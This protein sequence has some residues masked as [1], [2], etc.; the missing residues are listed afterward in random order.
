MKLRPFRREGEN[1]IAG[2]SFWCPGCDR[3]HTFPITKDPK[4]P[5]SLAW[6]YSGTLERPNFAPS[7]VVYVTHPE[8][9][10]KNGQPGKPEWKET[11]CHLYLQ[12]GALIFLSDCKHDLRG[13]TV[14]LPEWP[15]FPADSAP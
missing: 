4:D 13:N 6:R 12:Q 7:L 3:A 15:I 9:P 1:D 8:E 14:P 10:P 5:K 2:F 11:L